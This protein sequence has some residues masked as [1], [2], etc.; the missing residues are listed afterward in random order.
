MPMN[1]DNAFSKDAFGSGIVSVAETSAFVFVA[2][3]GVTKI[4]AIK[5]RCKR[6]K[7]KK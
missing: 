2:Y 3:A 4:A 6:V 7:V 1:W 5:A